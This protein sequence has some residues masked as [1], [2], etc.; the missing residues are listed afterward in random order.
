MHTE[1]DLVVLD[2]FDDAFQPARQGGQGRYIPGRSASSSSRAEPDCVAT[3][4]GLA[5]ACPYCLRLGDQVEIRAQ[6]LEGVLQRGQCSKRTADEV[7]DQH[8]TQRPLVDRLASGRHWPQGV[9]ESRRIL[10]DDRDEHRLERAS[11]SPVEQPDGA[12]VDE[13]HPAVV[14]EVDVSG[15]RIDVEGAGES[16]SPV[17][18]VEPVGRVLSPPGRSYATRGLDGG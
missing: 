12:T 11:L 10:G 1:R 5:S 3:H 18:F 2:G 4:S 6:Q 8:H 16:A 9:P 7:I 14:G 13:R 17:G 15:L